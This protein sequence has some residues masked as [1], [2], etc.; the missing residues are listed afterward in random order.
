MTT[1][2]TVQRKESNRLPR[3]PCDR[4]LPLSGASGLIG[5]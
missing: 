2:L 4:E 3:L 5:A 1:G